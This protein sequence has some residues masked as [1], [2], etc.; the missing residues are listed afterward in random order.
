MHEKL[1]SA[2]ILQDEVEFALGLECV[3]QVD[4][5]RVLHGFK[6]VSLGLGVSSVLNMIKTNLIYSKIHIAALSQSLSKLNI[7]IDFIRRRREEIDLGKN[8]FVSC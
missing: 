6:D 7:W 5:E 3:H 8:L 2:Q 1:P 4:D